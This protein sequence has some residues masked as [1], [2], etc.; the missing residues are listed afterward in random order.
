MLQPLE[1]R[2]T[3]YLRRVLADGVR[4]AQVRHGARALL[5]GEGG[6]L[7]GAGCPPPD[8]VYAQP[9]FPP[10]EPTADAPDADGVRWLDDPGARASSASPV[11]DGEPMPLPAAGAV[12]RAVAARDPL[13]MPPPAPTW[14]GEQTVPS[15]ARPASTTLFQGT[16]QT[17]RPLV[18]SASSPGPDGH[19][20]RLDIDSPPSVVMNVPSPAIVPVEP[21]PAPVR[22][23][24]QATHSPVP[25]GEPLPAAGA[26][27]RAVA[28]RA[29]L[30]MPPPHGAS[31]GEGVDADVAGRPR[32]AARAGSSLDT[33]KL[34]APMRALLPLLGRIR[35]AHGDSPPGSE[36]TGVQAGQGA[37]PP[38]GT[39]AALGMSAEGRPDSRARSSTARTETPARAAAPLSSIGQ[40]G[41]LPQM[42]V[43]RRRG[44]ARVLAT[45]A[46]T[47]DAPAPG[48]E[49][50]RQPVPRV[51]RVVTT[52][53]VYRA[54]PA[55]AFW[56]RR[57]LGRPH[58]RPFR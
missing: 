17:P 36:L 31:R 28:A 3:G 44:A 37:A 9:V 26:V 47:A 39:P 6:G 30:D 7:A 18:A 54:A 24:P 56:E 40:S 23:V 45:N 58:M 14:R 43:A 13:D 55:R 48:R 53:V 19:D 49:P 10:I 15:G 52:R 32:A 11:P 41:P 12:S 8:F 29:P 57:Y 1:H 34:S 2:P 33:E 51:E 20:I 27:S 50:A 35:V 25:G 5:G 21:A 38:M 16:A 4:P 22:P 46:V 42:P